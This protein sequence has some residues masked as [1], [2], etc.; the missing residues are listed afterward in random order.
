MLARP[1]YW[2]RKR[3]RNPVYGYQ[4][5]RGHQPPDFLE[6]EASEQAMTTEEAARILKEMCDN[7][8]NRDKVLVVHLFGIVYGK[9]LKENDLRTRDVMNVAGIGNLGPTL[10]AGIKLSENVIL[11]QRGKAYIRLLRGPSQRDAG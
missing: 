5:Q 3:Q 11:A 8:H 6:A 4:W 1:L 10:N 7:A 9:K 2:I